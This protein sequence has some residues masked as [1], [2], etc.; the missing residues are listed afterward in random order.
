MNMQ[1][2]TDNPIGHDVAAEAAQVLNVLDD[3][4]VAI[5]PL[6][7]ASWAYRGGNPSDIRSQATQL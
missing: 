5:I 7:V 1:M 6:N 2:M 3:G 4:G